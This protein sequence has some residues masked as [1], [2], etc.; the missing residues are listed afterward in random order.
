MSKL[1]LKTI[2]DFDN[3]RVGDIFLTNKCIMYGSKIHTINHAEQWFQV[4]HPKSGEVDTFQYTFDWHVGKGLIIELQNRSYK[5]IFL[6]LL[7]TN[8]C[9]KSA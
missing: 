5:Q 7:K 9:M 1:E 2:A 3:V 8:S 6:N 4:A